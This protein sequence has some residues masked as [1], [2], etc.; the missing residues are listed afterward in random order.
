MECRNKRIK[1]LLLNHTFIHQILGSMLGE[2]VCVMITGIFVENHQMK[3]IKPKNTQCFTTNT[4]LTL[5]R[6]FNNHVINRCDKHSM[7][8]NNQVC[9]RVI[10]ENDD[11]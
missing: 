10:T 9:V 5:K 4:L 11:M 7:Y 2:Y 3:K 8:S 1:N 6:R